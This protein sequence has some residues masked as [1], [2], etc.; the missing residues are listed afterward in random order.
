[1]SAE[2][3]IH[4]TLA[5]TLASGIISPAA[6]QIILS[7]E[8]AHYASTRKLVAE[9]MERHKFRPGP[10]SRLDERSAARNRFRELRKQGRDKDSALSNWPMNSRCWTISLHWSASQTDARLNGH[11]N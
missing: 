7:G 8:H 5:A 4:E 10:K 9:L 1:M 6:M 3:A 11:E 2:S